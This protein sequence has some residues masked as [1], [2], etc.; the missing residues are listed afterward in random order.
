MSNVTTRVL[1]GKPVPA[2][3]AGKGGG[4]QR[5]ACAMNNST[6]LPEQGG[7][8]AVCG[9]IST[10]HL[11]PTCK[12]RIR[13]LSAEIESTAFGP[14]TRGCLHFPEVILRRG[15]GSARCCSRHSRLR[16]GSSTCRLTSTDSYPS[17]Y[18]HRYDAFPPY[19]YQRHRYNFSELYALMN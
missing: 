16:T 7:R 13:N 12:L 8:K 19:S 17:T 9:A 15:T 10:V 4:P 6:L 1:E 3:V 14:R 18:P 5:S 2:V 11:Y